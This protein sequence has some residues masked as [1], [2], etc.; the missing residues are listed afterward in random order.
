MQYQNQIFADGQEKLLLINILFEKGNL[1]PSY[2]NHLTDEDINL[3]PVQIVGYLDKLYDKKVYPNLAWLNYFKKAGKEEKQQAAHK[4]LS[5]QNITSLQHDIV[6]AA[7][8]QKE[9]ETEKQL[10]AQKY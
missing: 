8:N 2:L 3:T 9:N 4:I 6:V 10:A 7:F 1:Y 5:D